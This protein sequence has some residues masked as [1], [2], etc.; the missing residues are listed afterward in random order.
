[1][2]R[3]TRRVIQNCCCS[4]LRESL[5]DPSETT[6]GE[7]RILEVAKVFREMILPLVLLLLRV[8]EPSY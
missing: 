2:G 6:R 7:G 5:L 3:G 8:L 1:M 4:S